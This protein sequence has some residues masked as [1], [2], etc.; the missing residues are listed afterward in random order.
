MAGG[1][2]NGDTPLVPTVNCTLI[3]VPTM[4]RSIPV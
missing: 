3:W 2:G 4:K 1:P